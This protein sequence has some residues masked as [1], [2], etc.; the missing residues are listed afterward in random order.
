MARIPHP[1]PPFVTVVSPD[2]RVELSGRTL[3]NGV[4]KAA[5]AFRDVLD[6]EP[7]DSV[8]VDLGW[9]WQQSVWQGA[10]LIAGLQLVGG[11]TEADVHITGV[12][13]GRDLPEPDLVA[14]V[15]NVVEG[16]PS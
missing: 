2:G 7:G 9:T 4:A 8:V 15:R 10:A 5:N 3:G 14:D 16:D 11:T 6:T 1:D 12:N 13:W